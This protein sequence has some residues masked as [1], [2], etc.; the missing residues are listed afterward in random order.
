MV[1]QIQ[2]FASYM[3]ARAQHISASQFKTDHNLDNFLLRGERKLARDILVSLL[4]SKR[5]ESF[6]SPPE[7]K[8]GKG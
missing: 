3:S 5:R 1:R 6:S 7:G 8:D 4:S 2:M